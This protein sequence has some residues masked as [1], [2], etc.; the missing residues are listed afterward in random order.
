MKTLAASIVAIPASVN[1]LVNR[2]CKV[3]KARSE[4]PRV[5]SRHS[6]DMP[7]LS[8][9]PGPSPFSSTKITPADS[10][11]SSERSQIPQA[12]VIAK[13]KARPIAIPSIQWE[14]HACEGRRGDAHVLVAYRLLAP[15]S[16]LEAASGMVR[17]DRAGGFARRRL[18]AG[19]NPQTLSLSRP[20]V[21][22]QTS[23]VRPSDGPL[24]RSVQRPLRSAALRSDQH[25]FRGR[26][27]VSRGRQAALRLFARPSAR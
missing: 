3:W 26:A 19:R 21:G 7:F 27:A 20:A 4:R 1:S 9:T 25:L 5:P 18:R 24:A 23:A 15:G 16:E 2:S 14:T 13:S 12:N 17:A 10:R 6:V 11:V 8:L 22:T